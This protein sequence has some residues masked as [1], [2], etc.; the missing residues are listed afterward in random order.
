MRTGW[1]A[2]LGILGVVIA[3]FGS[4]LVLPLLP[5]PAWP[6]ITWS[7]I[8]LPAVAFIALVRAA[9]R[10]RSLNRRTNGNISET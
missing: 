7:V 8:V 1:Q 2:T 6:T 9:L 4:H 3:V 5:V 10:I